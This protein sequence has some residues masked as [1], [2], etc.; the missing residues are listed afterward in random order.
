MAF[1]ELDAVGPLYKMQLNHTY[2]RGRHGDLLKL[3]ADRPDAPK[4]CSEHTF[5][6]VFS[7]GR[8]TPQTQI[9]TKNAFAIL[10][11]FD[12]YADFKQRLSA[13]ELELLP[14]PELERMAPPVTPPVHQPAAPAPAP[15]AVSFS[16]V[17]RTFLA[18][19]WA[20]PLAIGTGVVVL[21][22][23]THYLRDYRER[24]TIEIESQQRAAITQRVE[25]APLAEI[26][27]Y[28]QLPAYDTAYF[29]TTFTVGSPAK[30]RILKEMNKAH[31]RGHCARPSAYGRVTHLNIADDFK[32]GD[33]TVRVDTQEKWFIQTYDPKTGE[34]HYRNYEEVNQQ[35]YILEL[36]PSGEWLIDSN[37]YRGTASLLPAP[38]VEGA[39][40]ATN[41]RK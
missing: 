1:G 40:L 22:L 10:A 28:Q 32:L 4:V 8:L 39:G 6:T 14:D 36:Q 17:A 7:K 34:D 16:T 21:L 30:K 35:F 29:D 33:S 5:Y 25:G 12:D 20:W 24:Q 13:G 38:P 37:V 26:N 9:Q 23:G 15:P 19:A 41:R 27:A 11:G 18:S 31:A 2:A 3:L